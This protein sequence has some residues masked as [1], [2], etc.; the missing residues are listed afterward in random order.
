VNVLL[1][2]GYFDENDEHIETKVLVANPI[3]FNDISQAQVRSSNDLFVGQLRDYGK[4][5]KVIKLK[6]AVLK[7]DLGVGRV[8]PPSRRQNWTLDVTSFEKFATGRFFRGASSLKNFYAAIKDP[9]KLDNFEK[10]PAPHVIQDTL[11]WDQNLLFKDQGDVQTKN[12]DVRDAVD[13]RLKRKAVIRSRADILWA[14]QTVTE[15]DAFSRHSYPAN[16]GVISFQ[17]EVGGDKTGM[18]VYY[19]NFTKFK[20]RIRRRVKRAG[21]TLA[22]KILREKGFAET[23]LGSLFVVRARDTTIGHQVMM[24]IY[25]ERDDRF[26]IRDIELLLTDSD[27]GYDYAQSQL[28]AEERK[29]NLASFKFDSENID[30]VTGLCMALHQK[31]GILER[32]FQQLQ[33]QGYPDQ[34]LM[35]KIE[36]EMN[37][38][39]SWHSVIE[40]YMIKYNAN[41][42]VVGNAIVNA[43]CTSALKY[44]Q[45]NINME[46]QEKF[47]DTVRRA[48]RVRNKASTVD[49]IN[50]IIDS[51]I[52]ISEKYGGSSIVGPK[53]A[54]ALGLSRALSISA[55]LDE[56]ASS[57]LRNKALEIY[58][59]C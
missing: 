25:M 12:Q 34:K 27:A 38:L 35:S 7:R 19:T 39:E 53:K 8:P 41:P 42:A 1:P 37:T 15:K 43:S 47:Y 52:E 50:S 2:Y 29:P 26:F 22:N 18:L 21:A 16:K 6:T 45:E 46:S 33:K 10:A 5:K 30:Q 51:E 23:E 32:S 44:L 48:L 31:L 54:I 40:D 56:E 59:S 3:G 58:S 55:H 9:K 49:T 24:V 17:A 36:S 57:E 20:Q 11:A 28:V 4:N 13:A 14:D